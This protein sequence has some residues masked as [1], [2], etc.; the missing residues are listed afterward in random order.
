MTF[1]SRRAI[2]WPSPAG[3]AATAQ[4]APRP[5]MRI[6]SPKPVGI[7]LTGA[8]F[9]SW[10]ATALIMREDDARGND[11]HQP[12]AEADSQTDGATEQC[13]AE[14]PAHQPFGRAEEQARTTGHGRKEEDCDRLRNLLGAEHV[15]RR[16]VRGKP[17]P[18][19]P[20]IRWPATDRTNWH[21]SRG[22]AAA[23]AAIR[24]R[25]AAAPRACPGR[26]GCRENAGR[27]R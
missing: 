27:R 21:R 15:R 12:E 11:G 1:R 9:E 16:M 8:S 4:A 14:V 5:I 3:R 2:P 19:T 6:S 17:R 25:R 18:E 26:T 22:S 13:A 24:P 23:A 10:R 7:R 20:P